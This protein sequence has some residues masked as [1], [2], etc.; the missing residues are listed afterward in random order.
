MR[1]LKVDC[2]NCH[3]KLF[4]TTE[5]YDPNVTPTGASVRSLA[6]YQI[7]WLTSS[8][9]PVAMMTC[10]EC[11]A[12]LAPSGR[13]TVIET[14]PVTPMEVG[15]PGEEAT[16]AEQADPEILKTG[17]VCDICGKELKNKFGLDGHMRSHK[18]KP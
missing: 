15:I 3:R 14:T 6:L 13:L 12:Q 10:P 1:G 8:T 18:G 4:E 5:R 9:T 2:P 17:F 7:D 16:I 11:E